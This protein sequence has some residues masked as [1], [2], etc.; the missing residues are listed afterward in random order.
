VPGVK[1]DAK[2][3]LPDGPVTGPDLGVE[4]KDG[5]ILAYNKGEW[6]GAIYWFSKDGR[7]RRKLSDDQVNQF[8]VDEGRI[9]AVQGLAHLRISEGSLIEVTDEGGRWSVRELVRLPE[10]GEAIAKVGRNEYA[11]VTSG[12][13]LRVGT[14]EKKIRELT[15]KDAWNSLYPT[16]VVIG[17][18]GCAYLGMQQ[19]VARCRIDG[20]GQK[21]DFL[22][23]NKSWLNTKTE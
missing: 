16:S 3:Q 13:L 22:V 19:F 10:C 8:L 1:F 6:G 9:V 18:D 20:E 12:Q 15:P 21:F 11:V 23:P 5:W 7:A 17:A 14:D 4:V 2:V